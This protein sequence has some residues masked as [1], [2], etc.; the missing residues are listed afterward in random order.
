MAQGGTSRSV[1]VELPFFMPSI[2]SPDCIDLTED[3]EFENAAVR[4]LH[5]S[6][7]GRSYCFEASIMFFYLFLTF[8]N[9]TPVE[10]FTEAL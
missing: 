7:L 4:A 10:N 2:E 9:N 8:K 1:D 5:H 6:I 3:S